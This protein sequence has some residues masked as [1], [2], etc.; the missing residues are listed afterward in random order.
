MQH[1]I[2]CMLYAEGWMMKC[3]SRERKMTVRNPTVDQNFD[4][5]YVKRSFIM[6]QDK[7]SYRNCSRS[8][9]RPVNHFRGKFFP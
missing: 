1:I 3:I 9:N 5:L 6:Q 4:V 7:L 2:C 8:V